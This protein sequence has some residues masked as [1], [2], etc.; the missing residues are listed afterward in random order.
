MKF[1]ITRTSSDDYM[2]IKEI[3]TIEELIKFRNEVGKIIINCNFWYNKGE[4]VVKDI[5]EWY[6]NV[7]A[8]EVVTIPDGIEIYDYYRE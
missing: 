4:E 1:V 5:S 7:N 2:E 3:S 8:K 6:P